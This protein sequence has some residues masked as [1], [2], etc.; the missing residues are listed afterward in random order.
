M[1]VTASLARGL[2]RDTIR[3]ESAR[4]HAAWGRLAQARAR[5]PRTLRGFGAWFR[6]HER[7]FQGAAI[8]IVHGMTARRTGTFSAYLP[9]FEETD[10]GWTLSVERLRIDAPATADQRR[11]LERLS[12]DMVTAK[13]LGGESILAKLTRAPWNGAPIG[14]LKVV[15]D[16]FFDEYR[17]FLESIGFDIN[18]YK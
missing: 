1:V 5:V 4:S 13:E 18:S 7:C 9:K 3:R 16:S 2:L 17:V 14:G 10:L 11:V 8:L 15:D 6:L 12:P